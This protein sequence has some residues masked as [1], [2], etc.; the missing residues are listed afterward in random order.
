MKYG[1]TLEEAMGLFS[2]QSSLMLAP[3]G[4]VSLAQLPWLKYKLV[5]KEI[6][7][8]ASRLQHQ[9][10]GDGEAHGDSEPGHAQSA[11]EEVGDV[12]S[13]LR[14]SLAEVDA[15]FQEH[16]A[17]ILQ[18]SHLAKALSVIQSQGCSK[19]SK[20][21][22]ARWQEAKVFITCHGLSLRTASLLA[23]S[24]LQVATWA[25][26]NAVAVY[27]ILKKFDKKLAKFGGNCKD[28]R[29]E[30]YQQR[31]F[32]QG[33]MVTELRCCCKLGEPALRQPWLAPVA[34][35]RLLEEVPTSCPVC[36]GVF[37]EPLGLPCGHCLCRRCHS[38]LTSKA[39][40]VAA[41]CPLCRV[42]CGSAPL[43][44][45]H[46]S[47]LVR[48][49]H[50]GEV[51]AEVADRCLEREGQLKSLPPNARLMCMATDILQ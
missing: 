38:T 28:F 2:E 50:K 49:E 45:R 5:K 27:K 32:L 42:P 23:N 22:S 16:A 7:K 46:L 18:N 36:F 19:T 1:H 31:T 48:T 4:Q 8:A 33:P 35:P 10:A 30:Q 40:Q 51:K 14:S 43:P 47:E 44:M 11:L 37:I 26:L 34:V 12:F 17:H 25:E 6:S 41:A 3:R 29:Q 21:G 20:N 9:K 24:A 13:M 39:P 15:A